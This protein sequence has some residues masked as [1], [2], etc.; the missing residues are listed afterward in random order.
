MKAIKQFL[1]QPKL[2]SLKLALGLIVLIHLVA[3][4]FLLHLEFNNAPELYFPKTAPAVILD[5]QLRTEFPTDE[6]L[7]GLFTGNNLYS[8]EFLAALDR[9]SQRLEKQP[10]VDRVLR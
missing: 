9:V 4:A 2:L 3:G 10:N 8:K 6:V 5:R 1:L 7:I